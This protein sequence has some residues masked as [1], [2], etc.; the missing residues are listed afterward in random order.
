[1]AA[2]LVFPFYAIGAFCVILAGAS[3]TMLPMIWA[4]LVILS[5]AFLALLLIW[6]GPRLIFDR[7]AAFSHRPV[8]LTDLDGVILRQNRLF[9]EAYG[10]L[11]GQALGGPFGAS[12]EVRALAYRAS[13]RAEKGEVQSIRTDERVEFSVQKLSKDRLFWWIISDLSVPQVE[14]AAFALMN[15]EGEALVLGKAL[16]EETRRAM[17]CGDAPPE[18]GDLA[19][20]EI[21]GSDLTLLLP[22]SAVQDLRGRLLDD[23]PASSVLMDS[24]GFIVG[25]NKA[26][27]KL[28]GPQLEVGTPFAGL[29]EGVVHSFEQRLADTL[30][31]RYLGRA[32]VVKYRRDGEDLFLQLA[33]GRTCIDGDCY[34]IAVLEDTTDL[35]KLEA[36]FVQS[37]KMQAVGQL[38]GG[39]AHDFNNLLTAINGHCDLLLMRTDLHDPAHADLMQ[40]RHNSNRAAALVRQLLAFSRKQTLRPQIIDMHDLLA[41][42]FHLLDRLISDPVTL[43]LDMP[44]DLNSVRADAR[45]LEQVIMNLVVNA[46]DA[47][48]NGGQIAITP[49]NLTLKADVERDKVI[50]P[51]GDYV[52]IDVTDQGVGIAEDNRRKIFDP[53]FTTKEAGAGTGLGLSTVYGIIKQT[54]GF[55]FLESEVGKGS[56]FS[57]FLPVAAHEVDAEAPKVKK[58]AAVPGRGRILLAE[59]EVPVR[60]FA[61]RALSMRGFDVTEASSGIEALESIETLGPPDLII[62][63][64]LMPG[65]DGPAWVSQAI[66]AGV[67]CPVIF[68]SG[69]SDDM[70]AESDTP[71]CD[72]EFL[73]KPFSLDDLMDVVSYKLQQEEDQASESKIEYSG[74]K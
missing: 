6:L 23:V 53:F 69:F 5:A 49:R 38:A 34:V 9:S 22:R 30:E 45:Q 48:P 4:I 63:D 36:Q 61:S 29:T 71:I 10:D 7:L 41:D 11:R 66:E 52:V 54:G 20:H 25:F 59:D 17:T 43:H 28:M 68:M 65:M 62:S 26:A 67:K 12:E 2:H 8:V 55:I 19:R 3:A 44:D 37:Q 42:L 40:I 31:S 13:V 51:R 70:L 56:T 47:M 39:V 57:V 50:V 73:G 32:E 24:K 74:A 60:M 58:P 21:A 46:R 1:M 18:N 33:L 64:V 15:A 35:K 16:P 72:Y 14:G 27:E